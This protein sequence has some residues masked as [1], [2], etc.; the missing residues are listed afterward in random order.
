VSGPPNSSWNAY[1]GSQFLDLVGYGST[2]AIYQDFTTAVG[3]FYRLTFAYANNPG[4]PAPQAQVAV[5]DGWG[6][7]GAQLYSDTITHSGSAPRNIDWTLYSAQFL[8]TT[9]TTELRFDELVG[10]GNAG[11]LLDAVAVDP[12][13]GPVVGA[14]LP[15]LAVVGASL[16]GWWRR[17]RK[18]AAAA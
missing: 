6:L 18:A 14:G 10:G 17:K 7:S 3:Q 4:F 13:P 9:T 5:Y 16:L 11:V 1:E 12:V 15:G 2:G 8:A